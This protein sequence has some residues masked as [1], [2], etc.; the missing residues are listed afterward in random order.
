MTTH[1]Q[2]Y[3]FIL[4]NTSHSVSPELLGINPSDLQ[5]SEAASARSQQRSD[6]KGTLTTT[7]SIQPA[8]LSVC[9]YGNAESP[10]GA[11]DWLLT[12]PVGGAAA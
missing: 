7:H 11:A 6:H 5:C 2:T 9:R 12:R 8:R 10:E 4:C 3:L 1:D